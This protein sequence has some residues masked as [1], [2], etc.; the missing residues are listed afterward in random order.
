MRPALQLV[1][2]LDA[3][4]RHL[5]AYHLPRLAPHREVPHELFV[6]IPWPKVVSL[7][8]TFIL[9]LL[10]IFVHDGIVFNSGVVARC[11]VMDLNRSPTLTQ[12]FRPKGR[13]LFDD[14][15]HFLG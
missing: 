3:I 9:L 2:V 1:L 11:S 6:Q 10:I 14:L 5:L 7:R 4:L 15:H 8:S 13:L 12:A